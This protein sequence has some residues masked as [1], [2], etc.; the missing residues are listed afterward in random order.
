MRLNQVIRRLKYRVP[1]IERRRLTSL[2]GAIVHDRS[3]AL[4]EPVLV[5]DDL[6]PSP[7]DVT[8]AQRLLVSYR[9][10]HA[11]E[12]GHQQPVNDIWTD[13]RSVQSDYLALLHHGTAVELAEY[14]GRMYRTSATHGTAQG[15]I[16]HERLTV[17]TTYRNFLSLYIK[18]RLASFAEAVGAVAVENPEQPIGSSLLSRPAHELILAIEERTGQSLQSPDI[19][20]GLFTLRS[21][22]RSIHERDLF[23]QFVARELQDREGTGRICEIGGGIGRAAYWSMRYGST[24]Y[25]IVDL[26]HINVLQGY[27]LGRA[28]SADQIRLFGEPASNAA[29]KLVP[30][31]AID[32]VKEDFDLVLNV[33]SF[34]EIDA[35]IVDK[36]LSW[37][38][39]KARALLSINQEAK[40]PKLDGVRQSSV[41]EL[42]EASGGFRR[43]SRTPF[44]LRRGYVTELYAVTS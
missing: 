8:L 34:P 42:V 31:F 13:I 21:G 12:H 40:A 28:I 44:W 39:L 7:A 3:R 23:A 19:D 15:A 41:P 43:Q 38:K 10:A 1:A 18:D 17:S 14:L 20:G 37:T 30:Y 11:A 36:Y 26:P 4:I 29:I 16:E 25:T 6:A 24:A 32:E 2:A 5:T 35:S 9:A 33:D 27:Y 22:T